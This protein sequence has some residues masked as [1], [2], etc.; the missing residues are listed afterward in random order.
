MNREIKFRVYA[1]HYPS[2]EKI[3]FKPFNAIDE[4]NNTDSGSFDED[5]IFMQFTGLKDKNGVEI[6]ELHEINNKYR[7]VFK[8]NKYILQNISNKDINIDFEENG[9]YE[10]T[11]EYSPI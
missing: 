2:K 6:Y 9:E 10:I 7:V 3:M 8:F 5:A 11:G 1:T 4:F